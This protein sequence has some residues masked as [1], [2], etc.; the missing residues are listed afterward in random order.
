MSPASISN[1]SANTSP[2][3]YDA[4]IVGAG[5]VGCHLLYQLRASGF[6]CVVL[7]DGADLGGVWHWNCYPGARVDSK[8]PIYEY[9]NPRLWKDWT[10]TQRYPSRDEICNYFEH[11][12]NKLHL[13]KDIVFNARVSAAT[14][15]DTRGLW[16]VI[17][18]SG[19]V[20]TARFF[21][22]CTGFAAKPFIPDIKGMDK[23]GGTLCHSS[24]WPQGG[25]DCQNKRIG[26]VGNGSS[27]LQII[28]ELGPVAKSLSVF[29]RSPTCCLPMKQ[30]SLSADSQRKL[31]STYPALYEYRKET[32][33]G[34]DFTFLSELGANATQ[35]E[36]HKVFQKVW[37]KGGLSFWLGTYPDVLRDPVINREAYQFWRE[38]VLPRI[39]DDKKAELLA[40]K[41]LPYFY[42][43]KRA[44]LEQN[45]YEVYNQDNVEI[46]DIKAHPIT[47]IT[48]SGV[49]TSDGNFR[50]LDVLVFATGFDSITGPLLAIDIHGPAQSLRDK[51]AKGTSTNLGLMTAGFPNMIILYGPHGPTSFCNGPTC[52]EMY[53]DWV[54]DTLVHMRGQG[55]TRIDTTGD[56]ENQ[57]KQTVNAIG[58]ATLIPRTDSE[59]MG[60]NIPGKV[61]ECINFLGGVPEYS[62]RINEEIKN[63]CSLKSYY[64]NLRKLVFGNMPVTPGDEA[65]NMIVPKTP[66]HVQRTT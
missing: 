56:A 47:E 50:E 22:L 29:Q 11:V 66:F 60:S 23:F 53:G 16:S 17:A 40:P 5:F 41:E 38:K 43:T 51:W 45:L 20:R 61:R 12:E 34:V 15:N 63:G 42:G 44:T 8:V 24:K 7:D 18:T 2:P 49:Y 21:L 59:Y 48:S 1:G 30:E 58:N 62:K 27:G 28:Q 10:W 57:W 32:Y 39:K 46:V 35:E 37:D 31:K 33:G 4:I 65:P 55:Y 36:R 13:K 25:I 26:V 64:R 54:L 6:N 52:A 19:H 14:W 3:D 9:S